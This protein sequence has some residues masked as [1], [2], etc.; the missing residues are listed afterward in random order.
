MPVSHTNSIQVEKKGVNFV[1]IFSTM[2]I[3]CA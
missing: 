3:N 1:D 2:E